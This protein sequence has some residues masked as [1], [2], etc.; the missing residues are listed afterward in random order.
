MTEKIELEKT[1]LR[2]LTMI[3]NDFMTSPYTK[4]GSEFRPYA[5]YL[6]KKLKGKP[7]FKKDIQ[8]EYRK[9]VQKIVRKRLTEFSLDIKTIEKELAHIRGKRK[10]Q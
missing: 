6:L 7:I 8:K 5:F 1:E 9:H 10:C 3:L 4:V 2:F